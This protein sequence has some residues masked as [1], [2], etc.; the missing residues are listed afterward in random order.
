M[1]PNTHVRGCL[2]EH[3]ERRVWREGGGLGVYYIN[4]LVCNLSEDIVKKY[5]CRKYL[6]QIRETKYVGRIFVFHISNIF[7]ER[8]YLYQMRLQDFWV[9]I[10]QI[11]LQDVFF[12][13]ICTQ[14]E[15]RFFLCAYM[16]EC[17]YICTCT[18]VYF[19]MRTCVRIDSCMCVCMCACMRVRVCVGVDTLTFPR[20][21]TSAY[22]VAKTH[23]IPYLYR[24]FSAKEPY[25]QW[26]FCEK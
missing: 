6:H 25:I 14:T 19:S 24:S 20:L 5:I 8:K 11:Y 9:F 15:A 23:R 13:N 18:C 10:C 12:L 17:M 22:R 16:Q 1:I 2:R 26:L 3:A 7:A 4:S 21:R